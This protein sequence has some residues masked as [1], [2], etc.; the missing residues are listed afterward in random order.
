MALG[1]PDLA[2]SMSAQ[3][4]GLELSDLQVPSNLNCSWISTPIEIK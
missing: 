4:E 1:M 3:G 2:A